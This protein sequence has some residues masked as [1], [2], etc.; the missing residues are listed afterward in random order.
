MDKFSVL[1]FSGLT[2]GSVYG[3][4]GLSLSLIYGAN[5]VIN[6]AQGEFVMIGTMSAILFMATY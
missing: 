5:R 4:V 2:N 3:L 6:F 1:L